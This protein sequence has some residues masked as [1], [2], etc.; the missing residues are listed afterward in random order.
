MVNLSRLEN[1]VTLVCIDCVDARRAEQAI[2]LCK[3]QVNFK[4]VALLTSQETSHPNAVKIPSIDNINEYSDFCVHDL[5]RYFSTPHCLIVQHDG[6]ITD[7]TQWDDSWLNYDYIGVDCR[8][9]RARRGGGVGGFSLRSKR[10]LEATDDRLA[11]PCG[12]HEDYEIAVKCRSRFEEFSFSPTCVCAR[13]GVDCHEV[14]LPNPYIYLDDDLP[15]FG[16]HRRFPNQHPQYRKLFCHPLG[17]PIVS[18]FYGTSR[19]FNDVTAK[20]RLRKTIVA[21]NHLLEDPHNG[22]I[23]VL[24]MT[25]ESGEV[26]QLWEGE[27]CQ[28]YVKQ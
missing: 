10:L 5:H 4:N 27:S 12:I 19:G 23:K 16:V 8:W 3:K 1:E 15:T 13:W 25:L 9:A 18:A 26:R 20:V 2:D 6:W 28:N 24:T 7:P 21:A 11:R 14:G 22:A 17:S